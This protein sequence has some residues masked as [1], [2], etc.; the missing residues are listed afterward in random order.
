[1][2]K[3]G[4]ITSYTYDA[5]NRLLTETEDGTTKTYTYDANGNQL[6]G[7]GATYTYNA[8]GQQA[9][10]TK[11]ATTASYTYLPTG[12]RKS[13]TVGV[14]TT[15]YVWDGQNMVYE[16]NG[17]NT[18]GGTAYYYGMTLISQ[19]NY[20]YYIYNGHGDVVQ[21]ITAASVLG[22]SYDYDAFGNEVSPSATDTNPFRY[23]GQYFDRETGTYYLRARYYS[24][25]VGRFTQQDGWAYSYIGD[26]LSLNLYTYCWNDPIYYVDPSGH[27]REAGYYTINGRY[28]WYENPDAEEFG[29]ESDT[30]KIID[31][32]SKRWWATDDTNLRNEL[33]DLADQA[34]NMYRKGT[35]YKY[36]EMTIRNFLQKNAV[37]MEGLEDFYTYSPWTKMTKFISMVK[38]GG[39]YDLKSQ[40]EWQNPY[41]NGDN[42]ISKTMTPFM[43]YNGMFW[44]AEMLGNYCF[45]YL[46]AAYGYSEEFLCFGAGMYQIKSG[47][48]KFSWFSTYFDDPRDSAQIRLGVQAYIAKVNKT[49]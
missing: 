47:T 37:Y 9:T 33:H 48:S 41:A 24:P 3:G 46:G 45:G 8:R 25:R 11:G 7:D 49:G 13:K 43:Y 21:L 22:Q 44:S 20:A 17:T 36:Y 38:T 4:V 27:Q 39:K 40:K 5:N 16:Y 14:T 23:A 35:P 2:S 12:L 32:L 29:F 6:T 15:N 42:G 1:M 10:Y 28:G 31:D 26:P 34:R 18:T 19:G 30:Y